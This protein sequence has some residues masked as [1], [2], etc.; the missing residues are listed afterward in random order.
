MTV[1]VLTPMPLAG[2][3]R[4]PGHH[5]AGGFQQDAILHLVHPEALSRSSPRGDERAIVRA[6]GGRDYEPRA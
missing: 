3:A 6:F 4:A 5:Q 1:P 2:S